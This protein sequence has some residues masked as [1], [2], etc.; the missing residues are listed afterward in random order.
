MKNMKLFFGVLVA[1]LLFLSC[2]D[3][4]DLEPRGEQLT[5][6]QLLSDPATYDGLIAKI[7]GGLTLG[8][9]AGGDGDTD[10]GGIDGGFS[11]YTRNLW[12][13][14]ELPTDEAVIAWGDEGIQDFQRHQWS[15]GNQYITAMFSR[16]NYQSALVNDF[17]RNTTEESLDSYGIQESDRV[18]IRAYRIEAKFL[19]AFSLYHAMDMF[20]QIGFQDETTDATIP[21]EQFDRNELFEYVESQLLDIEGDIAPARTGE[22]GRAD[23]ATVWMTLAKI[24]LNAE[25][26]TGTARNAEAL[27]YVSR[28]INAGY[29][30]D[31]TAP[32][33]NLFL[34]DNGQNGSQNEFIWTINYDG[35]RTQTFGGTTFLTH[36]PV[37]GDMNASNFGINGGWFGIRTTPQFVELF[38]GEE[39]SADGREMF[40]TQGQQKAVND[41]S[42]FTDGFAVA[43]YKNVDVNGNQGSDSTGD[44]VDIDLP[45]YR[46]ADAYLMYAEA[47]LRGGGGSAAE[48]VN[49]INILRERAYGNTG[50]NIT[51][52]DL[53]LDFIL[54]ERARELYWEAHR[55]QDLIRFN[56]FST[57]GIWAWKGNVQAGTT[58]PAFRDLF[59]IPAEQLNLN[60]NLIQNPGY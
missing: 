16:I 14:Q 51:T 60:D 41:Q 12:K 3:T 44:F 49:Y 23:Q 17:L 33:Q 5:A 9:Q 47:Q 36:A 8:G 37:G 32:Y 25:V 11:S 6:D 35:V 48:S 28:V 2:Q 53:D 26:Y 46:L 4:L 31:K 39:N 15:D 58:T 27:D 57:N 24:Y 29:V 1:S 40:F 59:P 18:K 19:R 13:L 38:P 21:G 50:S 20:G 30:I 7:Y 43:K 10:I 34:A 52:A 55:R 56:Q 22:Y 54:E 45:V 42:T